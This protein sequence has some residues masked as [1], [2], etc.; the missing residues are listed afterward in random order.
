MEEG[1]KNQGIFKAA[2]WIAVIILFSKVIGFLRDVVIANYYGTGIVS[3]AY[4]YAYQIPALLIVI[5]GG[6]GGPFHSATVAIFSKLI[7]DYTS[8]PTDYVKKLFNTFETVTFAIFALLAILCFIFPDK[9]MN[10]VISSGSD[11]LVQIASTHL[12][13]MS[14]LVLLGAMMGIYYGILVTYKHYLLPNIS[15]S[16]VSIGIIAI[17]IIFKNDTN[18]IHLA[19]GTLIGGIIQFIVQTP[20]V[21]KLG[22]GFTFTLSKL[23]DANF[24][25]ITELLLPAFLSSTI[26]QFGLYI[27]MFFSSGLE[28]GAWTSL[29]YANR[30]FQFPTGLLLTAI[31]VPLFPL[32]SKLVGEKK[33]T[34]TAEYFTKGVGSLFFIACY[35]IATISIVRF[36]AIAIAL[37]RGAFTHESTI[38]VA[39]ILLVITFSLLPYVFRDSATRLL[40]A[41]NDSKIP[42]ITALLAIFLKIFFNSILVKE[43]GIYGISMSTVI[44]TLINAII[45][46]SFIKSKME[47]KFM[48]M[49]KDLAKMI[50]IGIASTIIGFYFHEFICKFIEGNILHTTLR[51]VITTS[52]VGV[53]YMSLSQLFK[54]EYASIAIEKIKGRFIK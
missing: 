44:I 35:F 26:G 52:V 18:G 10:F 36:D 38:Q 27:D 28:E 47:Y 4:F 7:P 15:P 53:I 50:L 13:I 5:L 25:E 45:L 46:G 22:Y 54:I 41:F 40:Y 11:E 37:E 51:V 21:R 19:L 23:K 48:P 2:T 1:T 42:F 8:K 34:E 6:V 32:F 14:P 29:G 3:D 12:K 31:L 9:I 17:L 16:F 49:F 39:N 20:A 33:Y 30:I 43:Y 24:K